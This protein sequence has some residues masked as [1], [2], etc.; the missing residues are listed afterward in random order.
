MDW[1]ELL[2]VQGTLNSLLQHHRV[3][4]ASILCVYNGISLSHKNEIMSF[5]ATQMDPEMVTPS[6]VRKT[7]VI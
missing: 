5:E 6:D 1:L 2:A 3:Q 4:K 7:N